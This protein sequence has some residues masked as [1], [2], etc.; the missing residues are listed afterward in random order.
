MRRGLHP[1]DRRCIATP[2]RMAPDLGVIQQV[3]TQVPDTVATPLPPSIVG[4]SQPTPVY[5]WDVA[6]P[7]GLNFLEDE[8]ED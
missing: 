7:E 4:S 5:N 2:W 6:F 8:F 1:I 3:S